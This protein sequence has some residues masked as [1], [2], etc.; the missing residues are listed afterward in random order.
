M[1]TVYFAFIIFLFMLAVFDL[2]VGVSND[3]VNFLNSAI[4]AKVARFRTIL[5]IASVGVFVGA[6]LSNGMMD[7]ARHGIF[8]PQM[9]SFNDLL[10]IFLAVMVTD[11]VLLDVFNT[12]GMPTSTTVSLVFELLGGT[13]VL[14]LLKIASDATGTLSFASLMNTEKALAVILGIFLSVAIAFVTGMLVQWLAR[15]IFTFNYV[16]RLKWVIGLF[17]GLAFTAI[18]YFVLIKGLK[19]SPALSADVSDWIGSHVP[20]LILGCFVGSTVL[21]QVLHILRV[22]VFKLIV[23]LGTFALAMAF[24]SNDLVNFIGVP[25]AAFSAYTDFTVQGGADAHTYLMGVLNE[26]ARTPFVYLFL[27]GLIMVLALAT[28]KKAQ[29]VVKTSVDLSRQDEGEEMFGSSRVARSLVRGT[30]SVSRF[31]TQYV[32]A[33][34]RTWV[35]RHFNKEEVI[36]APGAAFDLVRASVNLVLASLLIIMGTSL[37]L[38][39]STTYVTFIVAMGSSLAD[40]AWTRESAVFR[41]T[42]VLNVIGGWFITAGVAFSACALVTLVMYYGGTVAMLLFVALA[43]FILIRNNLNFGREE[44]VEERD[45]LFGEMMA[46]KDKDRCWTLLKRHVALTQQELLD[47]VWRL[48]TDVLEG[49]AEEDLRRLRRSLRDLEAVQ[50]LKKK[51]RQRQLVIMRRIDRRLSLEKNTWF[52]LESNSGDQMLYCLKRMAEPCK[53]HVDNHFEPLPQEYL[54]EL[55][56]VKQHVV[57]FILRSERIQ[58]DRDLGEMD[59]LLEEEEAYKSTLSALRKQQ[60]DRM[61]SDTRTSLKLHLVYLNL[62]QETQQLVS[63]LRH[64]LRAFKRFQNP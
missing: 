38:P 52:H 60:L 34:V 1:G 46:T 13:F 36:L 22:N 53:E 39:L 62:L 59:E 28:S 33:G 3:A 43:V 55:K 2:I 4:G 21:M 6:T 51:S 49:F 61:Q 9:F 40:R 41:I 58:E 24:A 19:G 30:D 47:H 42:G 23:L 57:D 54:E 44:N 29:N 8:Q 48:Y 12:L 37:K 32:P 11:V 45:R 7:I 27:A 63:E 18:A 25:L 16:R 17:G 50:T 31:C 15:M 26:S 56:A 20:A 5:I 10:C 64:H 35:D 14:S